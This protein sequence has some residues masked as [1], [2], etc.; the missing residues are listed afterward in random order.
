MREIVL[1]TET[2][3]LE[4][5]EGHRLV[6]IGCVELENQ[7]PTGKHY[8]QYINPERDVPA[9][10]AAVHGLTT[11]ILK[12]KPVFTEIYTDFLDF[13]GEDRL[14]IHNAPFDMKFLNAELK[15]VGHAPLSFKRVSDSLVTAR[16]LFPGSPASL[17]A[18]C[19]RFNIDLSSRDLHG[20]LLDAQLLAEVWLEMMG[21]RQH[22]LGL[23]QNSQREASIIISELSQ[24]KRPFREPR[25]HQATPEEHAAHQDL[26]NELTDPLWKD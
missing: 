1:D 16:A 12:D 11:D 18:L 25:P 17:D 19:R 7:V 22:G 8:H 20:A 2:T 5:S 13:V 4:P 26:C 14:V 23:D 3:G 9:E 6:E 21:G 24:K 10:A 15:L